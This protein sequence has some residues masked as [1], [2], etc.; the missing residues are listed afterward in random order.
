MKIV[1]FSGQRNTHSPLNPKMH[2]STALP[3]DRSLGHISTQNEHM[4]PFLHA[5]A[6]TAITSSSP[7]GIAAASKCLFVRD[8]PSPSV[9]GRHSF[10]QRI[11]IQPYSLP[12]KK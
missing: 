10:W 8:G 12:Y 6:T 11:A 1:P 3:V 4:R 5:G 2:K 9:T 7:N